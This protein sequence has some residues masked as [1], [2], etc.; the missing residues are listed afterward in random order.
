MRSI[1]WGEKLWH[2]NK[3][4]MPRPIVTLARDLNISGVSFGCARAI[5]GS[6]GGEAFDV[7]YDSIPLLLQTPEM[8]CKSGAAHIDGDQLVFDMHLD[9]TRDS[10][11][12]FADAVARIES[13]VTDEFC[14]AAS[15]F[16]PLIK[17]DTL[18]ISVPRDFPVQ[19]VHGNTLT[20]RDACMKGV[21]VAMILRCMGV[22]RVAGRVGIS[23]RPIAVRCEIP[24]VYAFVDDE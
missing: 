23:W 2:G 20:E 16:S 17:G 14:D 6:C 3:R 4:L 11:V 10:V 1:T 12:R 24:A 13:V 15:R 21:K 18:R 5:P 22:W 9:C 8:Q 19:D 7:R